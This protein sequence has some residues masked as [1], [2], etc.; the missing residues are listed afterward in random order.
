M[1]NGYCETH[2]YFFIALCPN[3]LEPTTDYEEM[4][5]AW[6]IPIKEPAPL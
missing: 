4:P 2:M 5:G 1:E 6:K 3:K